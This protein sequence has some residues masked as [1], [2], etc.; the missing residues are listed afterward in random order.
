MISE[1]EWA[2][3]KVGSVFYRVNKQSKSIMELTVNRFSD[4]YLV[5]F[6]GGHEM[7]SIAQKTNNVFITLN[8]ADNYL[9]QLEQENESINTKRI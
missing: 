4:G 3:L 8:E 2:K 7:F 6:S 1:E 9:K 5:A